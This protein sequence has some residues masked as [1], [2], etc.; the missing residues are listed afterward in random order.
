M[1]DKDPDDTTADEET[2]TEKYNE[3]KKKQAK[4]SDY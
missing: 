4:Y 2:I 3:M 1:S